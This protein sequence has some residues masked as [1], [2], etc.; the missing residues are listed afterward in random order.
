MCESSRPHWETSKPEDSFGKPSETIYGSL[1]PGAAP[2]RIFTENNRPDPA[3]ET[4]AFPVQ[5]HVTKIPATL[6][7]HC[8]STLINVPTLDRE[9]V[10]GYIRC[11]E[12]HVELVKHELGALEISLQS[13]RAR[14]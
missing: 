5:F 12:R 8:G 13:F 2:G 9:T 3:H 4:R 7:T 1:L 6:P 11:I 14:L 10:R